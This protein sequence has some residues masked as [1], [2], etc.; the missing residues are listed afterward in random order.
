MSKKK[1]E[2]LVR[3]CVK[4]YQPAWTGDADTFVLSTASV[5]KQFNK[6][7]IFKGAIMIMIYQGAVMIMMMILIQW[8]C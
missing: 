2:S 8:P 3:I 4:I 7:I 1:Y 5:L 6:I